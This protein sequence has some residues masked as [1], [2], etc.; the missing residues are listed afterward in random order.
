[1]SD[2]FFS[3][4]SVGTNAMIGE[5]LREETDHWY[6]TTLDSIVQYQKIDLGREDLEHKKESLLQLSEN[7]A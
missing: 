4:V 2:T 3:G 6:Q 7:Y 1:M 5:H